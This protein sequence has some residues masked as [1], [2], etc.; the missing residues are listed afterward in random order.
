MKKLLVLLLAVT[1]TSVCVACGNNDGGN[2][3][4]MDE[5]NTEATSD[6]EES[7]EN[8]ESTEN[9]DGAEISAEIN[10]ANDIL[11]NAW[12]QYNA[13]VSE[14]LKFPVGGG[15][16]EEMVMDTSAKFDTTLEG[17]Q[18]VLT[19]TYC[20]SADFVAKT[21]DIATMMN[22]MMSNNFTSAAYH[23]TD[24][25]NV[26]GSVAELKDA[27]LNNQWMCGIPEKFIIVTV[28]ENYVVS[29]YGNAQVIDAF[30]AAIAAIYGDAAV[31]AVEESL[32]Q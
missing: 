30:N 19:A 27:M 26:E 23:V 32:A 8:T 15:N 4:A 2:A 10:E 21:D 29:A 17:A 20:A 9:A 25:A 7:T 31:V 3:G 28:G 22:M 6:S 14:D 24:A 13:T 1:I 12:A 5:V 18:D 11:A 16:G